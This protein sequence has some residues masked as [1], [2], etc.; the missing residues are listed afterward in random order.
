MLRAYF[1]ILCLPA[2]LWGCSP[3]E[4]FEAYCRAQ[5]KPVAIQVLTEVPPH[6]VDN[7]LNRA[8]I[9]DILTRGGQ[10]VTD[11]RALGATQASLEHEVYARQ[12]TLG[13]RGL[14][15][16]RPSIEV[17]LH[18]VAPV[19]Y[20]AREYPPG[21]CRYDTVYLH[22]MRHV[23]AYEALLERTAKAVRAQLEARFPP[24]YLA[25][26]ES[27]AALQGELSAYVD[28]TLMPEVSQMLSKSRAIQT[29]I[30]S[31]DEYLRITL[32]CT[33]STE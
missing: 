15:C 23:H 17:K 32:A 9:S 28:Q 29:A 26:G 19:V 22:E 27:P 21:T 18:L 1:L 12:D 16:A 2:L 8:E 24:Q 13:V 10:P 3:D 33:H 30:D 4:S 11:A 6:R 7:T 14:A 31:E 5:L 25:R 20:M